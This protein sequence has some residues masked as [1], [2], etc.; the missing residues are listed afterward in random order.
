M[1]YDVF[2]SHAS[3]DK[4][5]F[6][7]PLAEALRQNRVEV[8]YDEFT[9]R[10]G[11]SLRR[12]IDAGL[13]KSRFG[14][15]VLSRSFF[16]KG[17]PQWEL[18]GLVNRQVS[19]GSTV[20]LPI[21]HGVGRQEIE[22]YS[23]SLADKV[24][25]PSSVGLEEVVRRLLQ[26]IHPE[27]STL[28]IARDTLIEYGWEP[29][30]VTDDWWL[31]VLEQS[32]ERSHLRLCFRLPY[33]LESPRERGKS[34]AWA[35]MQYMWQENADEDR[36]SQL[37]HPAEIC[38]EQ[39]DRLLYFFP[40]LGI[41]GFGG[42]L[43][44][45]FD[46]A[47]AESKKKH[48][49][50]RKNN[51]NMAACDEEL[52]LR[53]PSF[54]GWAARTIACAFGQGPGDGIG[55]SARYYDLIDYAVWL[56]SARSDW[57]PRPHHAFLLDGMNDWAVWPWSGRHQSYSGYE[58]QASTGS[59]SELLFRCREKPQAISSFKLSPEARTDLIDRLSFSA[60]LLD[61]PETGEELAQRFLHAGFIE[62]WLDQPRRINAKR[63]A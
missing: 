52:A 45:A 27:G 10:P 30:V 44:P 54:G 57:L 29:P 11:D 3:E 15:V 55:P 42:Y 23:H 7:R 56:L 6:V 31:D 28:L 38:E 41:P 51:P 59:L 39:P 40:Q 16:S 25:I 53:H 47:L 32:Y 2:V 5:D 4:D 33:S 9:L 13:A 58:D 20:I 35:A 62:A 19:G 26:V 17:W 1:M 12:S 24:A 49:T 48:D 37:T 43:E 8:W 50:Y 18:D 60:S 36:I 14:I 21:W 46:R 61:L 63:E 22:G 34:L